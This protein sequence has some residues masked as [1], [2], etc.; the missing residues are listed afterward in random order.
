MAAFFNYVFAYGDAM[1][2]CFKLDEHLLGKELEDIKNHL[3]F[4]LLKRK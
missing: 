3:D 1:I 2:S 4:I